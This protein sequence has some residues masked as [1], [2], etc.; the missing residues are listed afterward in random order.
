MI[1]VFNGISYLF[2]RMIAT[3]RVSN[4]QKTP[5]DYMLPNWIRFSKGFSF[6]L[7]FGVLIIL[8]IFSV[9]IFL[10]LL[11]LVVLVIFFFSSFFL[12]VCLQCHK[13]AI[14]SL[15]ISLYPFRVS[16]G[17]LIAQLNF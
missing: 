16:F 11:L 12:L 2:V 15:F 5:P 17:G 8:H 7:R 3:S 14:F 13:R 9:S 4:N 6:Q 1:T 10:L